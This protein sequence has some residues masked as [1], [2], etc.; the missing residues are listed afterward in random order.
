MEVLNEKGTKTTTS[1][2]FVS[3]ID[4][5]DHEDDIVVKLDEETITF[6]D[7]PRESRHGE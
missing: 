2:H 5:L 7:S 6:L 4:V 1:I 3:L